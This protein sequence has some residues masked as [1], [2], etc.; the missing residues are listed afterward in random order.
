VK[1]KYYRIKFRARGVMGQ[2]ITEIPADSTTQ[3]KQIVSNLYDGA[4]NLEISGPFYR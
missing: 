1:I 2:I 4:Y 3:V